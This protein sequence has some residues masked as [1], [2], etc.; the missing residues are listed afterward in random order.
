MFFVELERVTNGG[1]VAEEHPKDRRRFAVGE[2]AGEIEG[3][4]RVIDQQVGASALRGS[5]G[6][7]FMR[8]VKYHEVKAM[9]IVFS[10]VIHQSKSS[11]ALAVD[12]HEGCLA[13][14][15]GTVSFEGVRGKWEI[16]QRIKR[17]VSAIRTT[18]VQKG[19]VGQTDA[20]RDEGACSTVGEFSAFTAD[21]SHEGL[22]G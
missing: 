18:I 10:Q 1:M 4:F 5:F 17:A 6:R 16:R 11:R 21:D 9:R 14:I 22:L 19:G 3:G 15:A 8:F 12:G 7:E 20:L 13:V 2:G